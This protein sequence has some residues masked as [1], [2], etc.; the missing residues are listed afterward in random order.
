MGIELASIGIN[1]K[2]V[3]QIYANPRNWKRDTDQFQESTN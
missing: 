3:N 2:A 1:S